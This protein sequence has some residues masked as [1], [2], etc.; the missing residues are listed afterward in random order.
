MY[1]HDGQGGRPVDRDSKDGMSF[2]LKVVIAVVV[3]VAASLL[4]WRFVFGPPAGEEQTIR[5]SGNIEVTE[6]QV[7]F[8]LA[9]RVQERLV[10]EGVLVHKDQVIAR[11]EGADLLADRVAQLG[12][13]QAAEAA[14]AEL[15]A[16]SGPRKSRRPRPPWARRSGALKELLAG[17]RKQQMPRPR[18]TCNRPPPTGTG[19]CR[20]TSGP[21]A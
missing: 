9:G 5:V 18:Q 6:A 11:L 19:R 12:E 21:A 8:K 17:S 13:L 3:V 7:A 10:N 15:L 16:G 14:L 2:P 20:T 1:H 4:L